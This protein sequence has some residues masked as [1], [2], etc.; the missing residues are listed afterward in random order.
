M[1]VNLSHEQ[2]SQK[3]VSRQ[4]NHI[5]VSIM[6]LVVFIALTLSAC[7]LKAGEPIPA[8]LTSSINH[9]A[10][11]DLVQARAEIIGIVSKSLHAKN[12]PI[13]KNVFDESSRLLIG[14]KTVVTPTGIPL[15]GSSNQSPIVFELLKQNDNCLL[16]RVDT[17]Q[18][19][20]LST[21]LCIPR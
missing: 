21:R 19:W 4:F 18:I 13:A 10:S 17:N 20:T 14:A 3:P 9:D 12:I 6:L 1:A 5:V 8:I 15:Y 2:S 11:I 16:K 7:S